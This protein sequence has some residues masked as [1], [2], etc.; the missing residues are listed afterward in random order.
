MTYKVTRFLV[1][2]TST[3]VSTPIK[4]QYTVPIPTEKETKYIHDAD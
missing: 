1:I 4:E 2:P 3:G